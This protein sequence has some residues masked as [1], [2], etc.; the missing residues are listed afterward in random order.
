MERDY[1][2]RR[3]RRQIN[4]NRA[5][6]LRLNEPC[7]LTL[8]EWRAI[9]FASQGHCAYCGEYIGLDQLMLEHRV[10]LGF[11]IGT[12]ASNVTTACARCNRLKAV[13]YRKFDAHYIVMIDTKSGEDQQTIRYS[14]RDDCCIELSVQVRPQLRLALYSVQRMYICARGKWRFARMV[15]NNEIELIPLD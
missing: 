12:V 5:R 3:I 4:I 9:L 13:D 14:I 10:S 11:G 8:D 6:A 15:Y 7:T 1:L 2:E